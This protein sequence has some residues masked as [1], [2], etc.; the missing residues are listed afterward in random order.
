MDMNLGRFIIV[1]SFE[2]VIALARH[3]DNKIYKFI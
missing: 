3:F 2:S 1:S